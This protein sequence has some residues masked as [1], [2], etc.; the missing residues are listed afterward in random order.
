MQA[1]INGCTYSCYRKGYKYFCK[2]KDENC[3]GAPALTLSSFS[4]YCKA[5]MTLKPGVSHVAVPL[6]G[7][8][9][10]VR[11]CVRKEK[12]PQGRTDC[13]EWQKEYK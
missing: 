13:K 10:G 9:S 1:K 12:N 4:A 2:K 8:L 11:E 7:S 6:S 5:P 3:D